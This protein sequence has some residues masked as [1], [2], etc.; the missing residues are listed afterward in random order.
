M[1]HPETETS[2]VALILGAGNEREGVRRVN[3]F[4]VQFG[5]D[6]LNVPRPAGIR[7]Q[8]R[9]QHCLCDCVVHP[10]LEDL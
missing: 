10:M 4:G 9:V 5:Y 3:V 2:G 1:F 8:Q 7:H 6:R